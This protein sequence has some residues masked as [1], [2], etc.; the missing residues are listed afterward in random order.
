MK[1][2]N[3]L[4]IGSGGREHAIAQFLASSHRIG[5]LICSPGNPGTDALGWNIPFPN[6]NLSSWL[7]VLKKY[8]ID[9]IVIGPEKP[10]VEGWADYFRGHG[11]AV[12]GPSAAAAQ[13]E[14][15]K[16]FSK[17]FMMRHGIPTAS[18]QLF[19]AQQ[20]SEIEPWIRSNGRFPVVI[21]ADGLAGG[22][23]VFICSN[24][25]EVSD[26]IKRFREESFR[27][28]AQQIVVED[29][30]EGEELS[31]FV[32]TDGQTYKILQHAQ[33][34]KKIGE[35]DTGLNTGGMGAYAPVP[36]VNEE[37]LNTIETTIIKPTL[38][39]MKEE[40]NRYSGILYAGLM[41]T[42]EGPKVVEYNCRF[43]DPE[44]QVILPTMA[45]D[46]LELMWDTANGHL[47]Q[48]NLALR[49][50]TCTCIVLASEGYPESYQTGYK[51]HGLERS[52]ETDA[53]KGTANMA[54]KGASK[55]A[56]KEQYLFHAGTKASG[57]QI[58]T[59]GGRVL[60][61]VGTGHNLQESI[62]SAYDLAEKIHFHHVYF[63]K[64][65]GQKGLPSNRG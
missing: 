28:A 13:L 36:F 15:S 48:H 22:K 4:L 32:I 30:M 6:E 44:C 9:L 37:L 42:K 63:R 27:N 52:G 55:G 50:I 3:V 35:G 26:T 21:K 43:G 64:D 10:L 18:Y 56:I 58:L 46:L 1:K 7:P 14:G 38:E 57:K 40:G 45:S 62:Q 11:Y 16:S 39:G 23:G 2:L 19:T 29:F 8:S 53:H 31:V 24:M 65:I 5:D 49:D 61:V 34:H 33:D 20:E 17:D 12:F 54:A 51:I 47:D 41:L 60:N 59:N 25:Q